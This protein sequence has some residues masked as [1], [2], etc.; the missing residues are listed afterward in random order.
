MRWTKRDKVFMEMAFA[1]AMRV[2]GKTLPNPPV[3][4]V[5]VKNGCAVGK[6]GT[7]AAGEAHAEISALKQARGSAEGATLYVTLEPCCHFGK[8]PPCTR[9]IIAAGVKRVVAACSDPNP[10]VAGQGF[11]ELRQAGIETRLGLLEEQGREF[12]EGFFFHILNGR[13]KIVIKIAQSVDGRINAHPGIETAI[14]NSGAKF[15]SHGLRAKADAILIGGET[16][17][18][19]D[20]DLTPRLV[21]GATP[22]ALVLTRSR[23]LEAGYRLFARNRRSRTVLL[24]PSLVKGVP[25][26]V[27]QILL[28]SGSDRAAV[29][30]RSLM[31]IFQHRGYHMVLLEG[32]RSIWTPFLNSGLWDVF[33]LFTAPKLLPQG[34]RWDANLRSGWVKALE[35]HRFYRFRS[36]VLTEFHNVHGNRA[37]AG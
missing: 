18:C 34:Q 36:D 16:L 23:R 6:G 33:Y 24:A 21:R 30:V 25:S 12:Y 1:E 31:R 27:E 29:L 3:G 35:F 28:P 20:P 37:G 8:T 4:A 7:R 5:L 11:A 15:F 13:P 22:E 19:D 32:G 9:A 2:K 14:T 10:K 17:R 26:W